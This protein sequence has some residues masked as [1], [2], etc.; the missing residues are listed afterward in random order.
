[1]NNFCCLLVILIFFYIVSE[2][3]LLNKW[4]SKCLKNYF[5]CNN[6]KSIYKFNLSVS[7][8]VCLFVSNKRQ[9]G[10]TDEAQILCGTHVAPGKVYGQSDFKYVIL[11]YFYPKLFNQSSYSKVFWISL[12]VSFG[13]IFLKLNNTKYNENIIQTWMKWVVADFVLEKNPENVFLIKEIW[14]DLGV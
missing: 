13:I 14:H 11:K 9:N 12:Y 3:M 7:L 10:W 4:F 1:M 5:L 2:S 8:F 6:I